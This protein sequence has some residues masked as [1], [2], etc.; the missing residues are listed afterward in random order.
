MRF[1]AEPMSSPDDESW[2]PT[3]VMS[4]HDWFPAS[5]VES[6]PRIVGGESIAIP[7]VICCP[8]AGSQTTLVP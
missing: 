6:T 5:P 3:S 4:S 7:F 8:N 2:I 1:I